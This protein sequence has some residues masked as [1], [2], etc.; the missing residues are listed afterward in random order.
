MEE[1]ACSPSLGNQRHVSVM[2]LEQQ[3]ALGAQQVGQNPGMGMG[4]GH[5]HTYQGL[6]VPL[7]V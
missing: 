3:E 1:G 4:H 5:P 2:L 7:R 6:N